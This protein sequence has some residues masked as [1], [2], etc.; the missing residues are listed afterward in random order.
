MDVSAGSSA[1]MSSAHRA[2]LFKPSAR[3]HGYRAA[4]RGSKLQRKAFQS[5]AQSRRAQNLEHMLRSLQHPCPHWADQELVS[6][7]VI[8]TPTQAVAA[9]EK[10]DA[11]SAAGQTSSVLGEQEQDALLHLFCQLPRRW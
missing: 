4:L 8:S 6:F 5:Q 7:R 9:P 1:L 3:P 2:T 10:Q 11:S